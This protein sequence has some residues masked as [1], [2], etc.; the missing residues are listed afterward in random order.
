MENKTKKIVQ[1]IVQGDSNKKTNDMMLQ[2]AIQQGYVS[3][4]CGQNGELVMCLV[5]GGKNPCDG[6]NVFRCSKQQL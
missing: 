2:M 1:K 5:N 4:D 3:K 6:C